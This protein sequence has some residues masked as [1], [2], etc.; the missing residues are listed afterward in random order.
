MLQY[1]QKLFSPAQLLCNKGKCFDFVF[2]SLWRGGNGPLGEQ[3]E[4]MS[5]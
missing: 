4:H 1:I 3:I 2:N 5:A